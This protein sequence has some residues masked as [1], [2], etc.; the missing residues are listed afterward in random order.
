MNVLVIDTETANTIE[1]PMP[2][3]VGYAI[4]DT[5]T[6][7]ILTEKSFVVAEIFL[8]KELMSNAYF[9]EKVPQ[10]WEGIK[11]G[12]R[13]MKSVCN[14]RKQIFA[15]MK[16]YHVSKVGA[17]NMGFDNRATKNDIRYISGSMIR[18]F[19]PYGTELFCIWNMA[20]T[21]ILNTKKYVKF[22][23]DNGFVSACGNVQTSAEIAYRYLTNQ[24]DFV[25]SHTGLEDVKI[26][27]AIMLAVLRS[28]M[29]YSDKINSACWQ[30][31][32]KTRRAVCGI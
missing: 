14:I 23:L 20:C 7:E 30:K 4:V 29:E 31:V 1:Q 12:T 32:Q 9:A 2:Y 18:W 15:D 27:V 10:Y 24:V 28:E 22:A 17:Y 8:D 16:K 6:G 21:S 26:E 3:D 13:V 25:E 11:N 19:F 5:E